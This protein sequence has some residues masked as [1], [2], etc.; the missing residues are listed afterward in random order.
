[1]K[2]SRE[3]V[4]GIFLC[5]CFILMCLVSLVRSA[6]GGNHHPSS[7][8]T[9]PPKPSWWIDGGLKHDMAD[10]TIT[11]GGLSLHPLDECSAVLFSHA[12]V[13]VQK[14]LH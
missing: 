9:V 7:Q 6:A 8:L 10:T 14:Q 13:A 12:T 1:M 2:A 3:G 5:I 11:A 4:R